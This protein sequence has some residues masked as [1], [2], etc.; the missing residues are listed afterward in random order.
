MNQRIDQFQAAKETLK[1]DRYAIIKG[2]LPPILTQFAYRY[3]TMRL[4]SGQLNTNDAQMPGTPSAYA[5]TFMETLMEMSLPH[6]AQVAGAE[7]FPTYSYFR[8]YRK[9][10][11]LKPHID[12]PACEYSVTICLGFNNGNEQE[13]D[14]KW[15][16]YMDG[17]RDYRHCPTKANT[18][19]L[20]G[21][22][23]AA[24]LSP[25]DAV[26]Y[27]G[28]EAKHWR[29]P[30]PGNHHAQVFI[31]YVDKN[32]PYAE[33]R[34][35][36]RPALGM[37]AETISDRRPQPY[38]RGKSKVALCP[39][40]S[41]HPA[42]ECCE[43]PK[44]AGRITPLDPSL[45]PVTLPPELLIVNDYLDAET[46]D[47][48]VKYS[49]KQAGTPAPVGDTSKKESVGNTLNENFIADRIRINLDD[50]IRQLC[51]DLFSDVYRNKISNAANIKMEWFE[52]PHILR[53]GSG[54]LYKAH[55][56]SENWDPESESWVKGIDRDYSC[57]LYLNSEFEGGTLAFPNYNL[58]LHP[59]AGMLVCFPSDHRFLHHAEEVTSGTR[60]AMVTWGAATGSDCVPGGKPKY[61]IKL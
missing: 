42:A 40:G 43:R 11:L 26:V 21:E 22:G 50:D 31:H 48:L 38:F 56:D 23:V 27:R 39:C 3:A 33:N 16:I 32:G 37:G 1:R 10:D 55:S 9:G 58:R 60:Y 8:V 20:E 53:Y 18:K 29:E 30:F 6:V 54:G 5:D 12:R 45:G 28:C 51:L 59:C 19:P 41:D 61:P 2:F 4:T 52:L 17:T 14:Y 44:L 24:L 35:D 13:P 25:G 34:F 49:D 46:C 47:R 57:V 15:P 36:K 7:L